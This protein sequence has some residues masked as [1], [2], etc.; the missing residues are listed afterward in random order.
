MVN[1]IYGFDDVLI[2]C[3]N[4]V[5]GFFFFCFSILISLSIGFFG[6]FWEFFLMFFI[7]CI[8]LGWFVVFLKFEIVFFFL[9]FLK[10]VVLGGFDFESFFN[11]FIV[12]CEV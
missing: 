11:C 1:I 9:M 4:V 3:M 5:F 6:F 2:L 12:V 8:F 10:K 7:C